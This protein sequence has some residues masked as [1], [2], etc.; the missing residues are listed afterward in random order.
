MWE[1]IKDLLTTWYVILG[2]IVL[3]I[4]VGVLIY[5]RSNREEDED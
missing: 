5:L 4:L 3:V 1:V 2:L